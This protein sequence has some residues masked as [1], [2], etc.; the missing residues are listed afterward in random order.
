MTANRAEPATLAGIDTTH[1]RWELE[2]SQIEALLR[3]LNILPPDMDTL[4]AVMASRG[5]DE[6]PFE[7][8][9]GN[10]SIDLKAATARGLINGVIL[11][12]ALAAFGES[13][14]PATVLSVIVPLL[15]D[16]QRVELSPSDKYLYAVLL[17]APTNRETVDDWY[18]K[19]PPRVRGEITELEFRDVVG[20]LE[21]AGAVET[22][23]W[24]H[25][26]VPTPSHRRLVKLALPEPPGR[27]EYPQPG[28][29]PRA[30]GDG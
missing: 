17:N 13:S 12:S 30:E 24:G 25:V 10:W 18:A 2:H 20:R 26:D 9:I 19:L 8:R 21:D 29:P 5:S 14:V 4:V 6:P 28:I 22:D 16:L 27:S 23:D 3:S 15:F 1:P 7:L 11:A